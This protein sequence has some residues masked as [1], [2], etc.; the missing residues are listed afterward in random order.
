MW[1]GFGGRCWLLGLYGW[2][3][4][5]CLGYAVVGCFDVV[6]IGLFPCVALCSWLFDVGLCWLV[7]VGA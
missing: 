3:C 5:L 7:W 1:L 6:L 4:L 2:V